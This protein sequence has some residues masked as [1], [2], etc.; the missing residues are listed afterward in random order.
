MA[1]SS[2]ALASGPGPTALPV[3][4][5]S[6]PRADPRLPPMY[7]ANCPAAADKARPGKAGDPLTWARAIA[8]RPAYA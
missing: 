7:P 5:V 1:A 4:S 8:T 6:L 3:L 2:A